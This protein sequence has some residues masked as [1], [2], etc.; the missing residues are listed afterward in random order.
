MTN[1]LIKQD[2]LPRFSDI[3]ADHVVPAIDELLKQS[4]EGIEAL[5]E[6]GKAYTWANLQE[7]MDTLGEKLDHAFSPVSHMNA[8]VNSDELRDAY[9]S[10]LP[11]LSEFS[12][13]VGQNKALFDAYKQIADGAEY[14]QLDEAQRKVIDN[15]LRDFHLAGVDLPD[16]KKKRFVELSMKLSELTSSFSDRVLD[17]TMAWSKLIT[18]ESELKGL[19]ES[20]LAGARQL[21]QSKGHDEGW[22]LSLDMPSYIP[23]LTYCE[24]RELREELYTAFVTRASEQGPNASEFDNSETMNE[25]MA[26]RE[27]LAGLLGFKNYAEYS[28]ATKMA[29]TTDE[30]LGFLE[31]L[32]AR[33]KPQAEKE[34]AELKAF[35]KDEFGAEDFQAW[36][37][38]F[39]GEKLRQQRY[40][41]SQEELRPWFPSNKAING[42][43]EVVSRLYGVTFKPVEDVDTWH[44]DVQFFDIER[45]GTVIGRFY[46]D[47]YARANKRG[48]AWMAD[49][50]NRR[51]VEGETVIPVAFLTCNFTPPVGDNPALL[52]HDEVVTLFHEFGH[53][54]HHMLTQVDYSGVSGISGVPWDAVELPSQF[55]ENWC[56]EKEA[57]AII[58]GHHETGEPLPDEMLE[59]MLAAKNFQSAMMLVRQLEFA[60]FDFRLHV[61]WKPGTDIQSVLDNVRKEVAVIVPPTFNRFQNSFSHIF[62]GGYAAGYY[63]Y[64]W[65]EVLSAD[66]FS[67]FEEDGIFNRE[68]GLRFL[69]EVLEKGGSRE[70]ADMFAAFRGRKP[71]IDALLRHK[72][73][74]G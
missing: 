5:L 7:P 4:R 47:L 61:G 32:A 12:T 50:H 14:A 16:E 55:M 45:D 21:A 29:S 68:T 66:A 3:K 20:A 33:S 69:H 74:S 52:T 49:C 30:V 71:E 23:V 59:K 17:A 26:S 57:L 53:G 58:S 9:N 28:I 41:I 62:A 42:M 18:D 1:P 37:A 56:W 36:D 15:A 27:E 46:L 19:P 13:W 8:V 60:L 63:S 70:P 38:G 22:M 73:I 31:D 48:G 25:I 43:F 64:L 67:K 35:A 10:C 34:L 54:L 40:A 51:K 65:A 72:G 39:Y 11:K 24:N 44:K 2:A 6:D